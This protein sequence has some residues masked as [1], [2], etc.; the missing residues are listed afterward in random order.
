LI[1]I[2]FNTFVICS[3]I[4]D[5]KSKVQLRTGHEGPEGENS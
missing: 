2:I 3:I 1:L 4:W 5:Y